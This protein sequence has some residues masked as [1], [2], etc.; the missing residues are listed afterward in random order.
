MSSVASA[1]ALNHLDAVAGGGADMQ[2]DIGISWA[3]Q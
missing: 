1:A 2:A 3:C